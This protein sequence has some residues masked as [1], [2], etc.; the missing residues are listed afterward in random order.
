MRR[1]KEPKAVDV[2]RF[3]AEH[4]SLANTVDEFPGTS[5]DRL[6]AILVEFVKE[7]TASQARRSES[8]S[9]AKK[10]SDATKAELFVHTARDTKNGISAAGWVIRDAGGEVLQKGGQH[11]GDR[12]SVEASY[13]ATILAIGVVSAL[14]GVRDILIRL[15]DE[16]FL[17]HLN[18]Q[19]RLS[20]GRVPDLHAMARELAGNFR[21]FDVRKITKSDNQDARDEAKKILAAGA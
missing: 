13:E 10:A 14:K 11:L 7:L 21:R 5:E 4:E 2:I 12:D 15:D 17:R 20:K 19:V 3:I 18:G 6:R 8:K 16:S 1:R 9:A